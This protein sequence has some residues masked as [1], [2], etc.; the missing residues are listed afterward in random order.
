MIQLHINY[1]YIYTKKIQQ[2]TNELLDMQD[3]YD[4]T[5]DIEQAEQLSAALEELK[6][7]VDT[8]PLA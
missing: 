3:K 1:L 7:V 2:L 5:A 4:I 6:L 8:L